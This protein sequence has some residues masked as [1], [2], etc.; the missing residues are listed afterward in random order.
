VAAPTRAPVL[1][2]ELDFLEEWE[3]ED[4]DDEFP[5]LNRPR[6]STSVVLTTFDDE[7]PALSHRWDGDIITG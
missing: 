2:Y 5:V 1:M 6:T 7:P 3:E 4:G